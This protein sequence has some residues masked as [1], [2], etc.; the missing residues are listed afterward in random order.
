[1]RDFFR[2]RQNR[3][4]SFQ[5]PVPRFFKQKNMTEITGTSR[6]WDIFSSLHPQEICSRT[7]ASYDKESCLFTITSFGHN[8]HVDSRQKKVLS[9]SDVGKYLLTFS[10]YFFDLSILWYLI[11]SQNIPLSGRLIKPSELKDGQIFIKGTHVLPLDEIASFYNTDKERF[12]TRS[13]LFGGQQLGIGDAAAEFPVF[14]RVPVTLILWFGDEEF[15]PGAQLLLDS[16]CTEHI[17]TDVLWAI[18]MV[19][20]L[21][22]VDTL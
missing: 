15:P 5:T 8:F 14:P 12:L 18:T 3:V 9:N 6:T 4:R 13:S 17:S 21:I 11:G 19:T 20:C 10:D 1:M 7:N 2:A 22:L 16:T